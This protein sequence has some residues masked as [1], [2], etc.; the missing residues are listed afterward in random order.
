VSSVQTLNLARPDFMEPPDAGNRG[1]ESLSSVDRLIHE[2]ARLMIMS[3]LYVVES[4]DFLFLV[5]QTGL[6]LGNLS[7][8][9][10][11]LEAAGYLEIEKSFRGKK[12]HTMLRL[13]RAGREAFNAYR[14]NIEQA[15][16]TLPSQSESGSE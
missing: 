9:M 10:S 5:R 8:H 1:I 12:P 14:Q 16:G 4:A 15:L 6:T 13:T 2:P 7:S 11:K 3:Y